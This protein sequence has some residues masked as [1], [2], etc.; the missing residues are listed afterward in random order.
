MKFKDLIKTYGNDFT[1]AYVILHDDDLF[2]M[3]FRVY[4]TKRKDIFKCA[5]RIETQDTNERIGFI[6]VD[7]NIPLEYL[8]DKEVEDFH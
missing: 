1:V 4:P 8:S 3:Y 2:H 6:S 7:A 5:L